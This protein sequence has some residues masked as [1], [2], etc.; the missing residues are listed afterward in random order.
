[1][2][3]NIVELP[4][5]TRLD[6]PADR[7]IDKAFNA[8]P[9]LTKVVILG[10]DENG[11]EYFTSSISDGGEVLWLIERFKLSLLRIDE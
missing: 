11:D 10:Y 8:T 9:S 2:K 5:I 7:V 6:L 1:M 3:D 4:V